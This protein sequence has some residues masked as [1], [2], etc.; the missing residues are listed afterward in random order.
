[1][2]IVEKHN[3]LLTQI[4]KATTVE[5][6]RQL[7][8]DVKEFIAMY[9]AIDTDAIKRVA[10]GYSDKLQEM[11]KLPSTNSVSMC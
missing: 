2:A 7:F 10:K 9:D 6:M 8:A 3:A 1:M 11:L 5:D 4:R